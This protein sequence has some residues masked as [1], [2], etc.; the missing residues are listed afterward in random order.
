MSF[1]LK[2]LIIGFTAILTMR[3]ALEAKFTLYWPIPDFTFANGCNPKEFVQP[4]ESGKIES[5][6][7]GCVRDNGERFHEG[8]DLAPVKHDRK[9]EPTDT[10]LAVMDGRVAYLN[11][12]EASS[13]YGLYLV[14]EHQ[15]IKPTVYTLYAHLRGIKPDLRIGDKIDAGE[16]V[17]TMGRTAGGYEIPA[18]RAHLH[19]EI[20]LRLS[21]EFEN[22]YR[23]NNY[24]E[25]NLH[26][27]YN[28]INLLGI[29]P[30][31]FYEKY[32]RREVDSLYTYIKGLPTAYTLRVTTTKI[33]AFI[34]LHPELLLGTQSPDTVSGWDIR[35]TWWGLPLEWIAL[36]DDNISAKKLG[37]VSVMSYDL[38]LLEANNC[39]ETILLT[40]K[41]PEIGTRS[42]QTLEIIFGQ[43]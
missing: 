17:G 31:D 42:H 38:E 26:G 23:G 11:R 36:E 39:R 43:L 8:L 34:R 22:W 14:L 20:G 18:Q 30:L 37:Q 29:D 10:I 15:N 19:F 40:D 12:K 13:S 1:K 28:G 35:F 2:A 24:P 41:G 3:G 9:G 7:F 5:A 33:P 16:K 4:T 6:L 27:N 25:A 21:D 32:K